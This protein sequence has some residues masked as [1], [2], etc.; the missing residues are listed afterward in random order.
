[1]K[2]KKLP[3]NFP[4]ICGHKEKSHFVMTM[5]GGSAWCIERN[6]KDNF[7][8]CDCRKYSPDNLKYLEQLSKKKGQGKLK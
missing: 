5:L 1:M 4:C 7:D 8:E 6:G 3:N 2:K